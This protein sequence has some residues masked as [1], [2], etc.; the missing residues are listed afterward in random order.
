MIGYENKLIENVVTSVTD[1]INYRE[2]NED[3]DDLDHILITILLGL[4]KHIEN[5]NTKLGDKLKFQLLA[6][7]ES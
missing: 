4:E 2:D 3:Y 7:M 1:L 5:K 6:Q